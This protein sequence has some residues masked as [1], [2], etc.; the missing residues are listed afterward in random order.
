MNTN[1]SLHNLSIRS[2]KCVVERCDKLEKFVLCRFTCLYSN[3]D[4][5]ELFRCFLNDLIL[6]E[7]TIV[8]DEACFMDIFCAASSDCQ[9]NQRYQN[10]RH[11]IN[12]PI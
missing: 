5:Y 11:L 6:L 9:L 10:R 8:S 3:L 2:R 7:F 12:A 4:T 1:K